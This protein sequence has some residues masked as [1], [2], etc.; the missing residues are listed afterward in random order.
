MKDQQRTDDVSGKEGDSGTTRASVGGE[1]VTWMNDGYW[2]CRWA[3][4]C[5]SRPLI[6]VWPYSTQAR[7]SS[8]I[9]VNDREAGEAKTTTS[10]RV[11][12]EE[13]TV[14][15]EVNKRGSLLFE[16]FKSNLCTTQYCTSWG[17]SCYSIMHI[18]QSVV[19]LSSCI[20]PTS[21]MPMHRL[22]RSK[23]RERRVM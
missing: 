1:V 7:C 4:I 22:I 16:D 6:L 18:A 15:A 10:I 8:I 5:Q 17:V 3:S 23:P 13:G 14:I 21:I 9:G 20:P 11:S 19:P 12:I 2:C